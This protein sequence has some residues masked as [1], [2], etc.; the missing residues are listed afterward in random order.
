MGSRASA[1]PPCVGLS[2]GQAMSGVLGRAGSSVQR[3]ECR[4]AA[5]PRRVRAETPSEI[6]RWD[7]MGGLAKACS[8]LLPEARQPGF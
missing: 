2:E 3:A 1:L 6:T 8:P 5:L 4:P 7:V